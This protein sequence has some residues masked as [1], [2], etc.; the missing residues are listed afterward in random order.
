[1][2]K[3]KGGGSKAFWTMLKKTT[4]S[5]HDGFPKMKSHL[6]HPVSWISSK[7]ILPETVGGSSIWFLKATVEGSAASF[8]Q[9]DIVHSHETCLS[10]M[11]LH[12]LQMVVNL[13]FVK[14]NHAKLTDRNS[15]WTIC[16]GMVTLSSTLK[17]EL[18]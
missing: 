11:M 18:E 6:L 4:L 7:E 9:Q 3:Q 8:W 17:K 10:G 16:G 1:M 13:I 15:R 5:L 2:F 12:S 14:I